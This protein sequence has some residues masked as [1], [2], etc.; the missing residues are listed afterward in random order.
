MTVAAGLG[1]G[2]AQADR[3][4]DVCRFVDDRSSTARK[5]AFAHNVLQRE[6]A[7]VRM[8]LGDLEKYF[9]S[10]DETE[11]RSPLVSEALDRIA[12]DRATRKRYLSFARDADEAVVRTRM[13]KLAHTLGWLSTSELHA[14]IGQMMRD[15]L[16]QHAVGPA[17]VDLFCSLNRSGELDA[18]LA[19]L[20]V[21]EGDIAH[22]AVRACLGSGRDRARIVGALTGAR[23]DDIEIAQVYLRH[24]PIVD[25]D[26]LRSLTAEI[27][28]MKSGEAQVRAL[29]T[30]SRY[31]LSDRASVDSLARLFPLTRS[32]GVQRA[33]AGVLL[34]A[35]Y[36]A[37]EKPELV[38]ALRQ[39]RLKSPTGEDL[40]DVLIR[41]LES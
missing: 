37:I 17:D 11:R 2:E 24:H 33:I 41:R 26:E 39:H 36:S 34:R 14:E 16:A 7:E 1:A 23:D 40:I 38:R 35:D 6:I 29:D 22:A 4:R 3:R 25:A 28:R 5:V 13:L 15:R 12:G 8:L 21:D 19:P 32:L 9:A 30:L 27:A 20:S 31:Q 18:Q 10:L